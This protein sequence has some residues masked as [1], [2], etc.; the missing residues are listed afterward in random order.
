MRSMNPSKALANF[1]VH[2]YDLV[3]SDIKMP[4]MN[5]YEFTQK[6]KAIDNDIK[7]CFL[8]AYEDYYCNI[9]YYKQ[10]QTEYFIRKPIGAAEFLK[11]MNSILQ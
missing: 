2:S 8:T 10:R 9:I 3:I 4:E 11:Q 7:I 1:K 5:G 6:V